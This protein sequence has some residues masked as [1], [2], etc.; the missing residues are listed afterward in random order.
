METRMNQTSESLTARG[1]RLIE[2]ASAV[3]TSTA[4]SGVRDGILEI[5][6]GFELHHGGTLEKV[7]VAYRIAGPV[8]APVVAALGGISAGRYVFA[9]EGAGHGWWSELVGP[10]RALDSERYRVLGIDFLGGN[11]ETTGP[12]PGELFPSVSS[13]DQAR[14]LLS[15]L[16]HLGLATLHAIAGASYGAMVALAFA[17][18]YPGRVA[19]L[20]VISGADVTHPMATAWRSLQRSIVRFAEDQGLGSEG[21][22]LA[23]A[24]A[25]ATYRSPEEFAARF[26]SAPRRTPQGFRFP[27]EDYLFARGADYARHYS[28]QSYVCLS[29][30]IDLHAIEAA[31]ITAQTTLVAVR[32]D[33]LVPLPDMRALSARLGARHQLFEISSIF[34]HDAFLKEAEQ[35]KPAFAAALEGDPS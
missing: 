2:A 9:T 25:M 18:R 21:V 22:K 1:P 11:G 23:R 8:R 14:I 28:P 16:N 17:E 33:Q 10:Q 5:P 3:A 19:R 31:L 24:L 26:R 20:L 12:R 35:L 29:E 34:G 13:Y 4:I 32:E 27:V 6:G 30:S 15:V 7:R